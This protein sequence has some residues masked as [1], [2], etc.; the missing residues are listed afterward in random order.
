MAAKL[1][2]KEIRNRA[3]AFIQ[4]WLEET[5]EEAEAK[6]FWDAFFTIFGINRKDVALFEFAVEKLD[7]KHGFIDLFWKGTLLVEHKSRGKSLDKAQ[8]QAFEY[9][10]GLPEKD[11]PNYIL[12]S[13]FEQFRLY[14]LT[15]K[16]HTEFKLV[17]L[18][19]YLHLF[20]F[21]SGLQYYGDE[22]QTALNIQAAELIR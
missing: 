13:D 2:H 20:D 16:K 7:K 17:E 1:H 10:L 22:A 19:D 11:K 15:R 4:Q 8:S 18:P 6:S 14:D 12:L 3:H 21:M 9:Y 5:R